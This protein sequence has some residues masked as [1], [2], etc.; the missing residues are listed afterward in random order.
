[1]GWLLRPFMHGIHASYLEPML[2]S[3]IS[4]RDKVRLTGKPL[5]CYLLQNMNSVMHGCCAPSCDDTC[6]ACLV[7]MS[8]TGPQGQGACIKCEFGSAHTRLWFECLPNLSHIRP[9]HCLLR[10]PVRPKRCC[11]HVQV[12]QDR[13]TVKPFSMGQQNDPE[14]Y[15]RTTTMA[16]R[17]KS[18]DHSWNSSSFQPSK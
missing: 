14:R 2:M 7:L 16:V 4:L 9:Q 5:A 13:F 11:L 6:F 12:E 1:M 15:Q 18:V 17:N 10:H 8:I 3:V